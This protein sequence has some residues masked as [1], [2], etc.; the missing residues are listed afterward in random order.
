M[1]SAL[2]H[3]C[4]LQIASH[5]EVGDHLPFALS[6]TTIQ[7][8]LGIMNLRRYS[9]DSYVE[10]AFKAVINDD[11]ESLKTLFQKRYFKTI[12]YPAYGYVY[13]MANQMARSEIVKF[14]GE[15]MFFGPN[16]EGRRYYY[17]PKI[18][19]LFMNGFRGTI[20]LSGTK[21]TPKF[22]YT[23]EV[24]SSTSNSTIVNVPVLE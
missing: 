23:E 1:E 15:K 5:L 22:V 11:L 3:D 19:T 13:L 24:K 9:A 8:S 4:I 10:M 16:G 20:I 14:L 7:D 17:N 6:C 18:P 21:E 2:N 12:L